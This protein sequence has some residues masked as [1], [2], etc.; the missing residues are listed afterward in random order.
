MSWDEHFPKEPEAIIRIALGIDPGRWKPWSIKK[1]ENRETR[2]QQ[3]LRY[4]RYAIRCAHRALAAIDIPTE[5]MRKAGAAELG[6]LFETDNAE[7]EAL[8]IWQAMIRSNWT[9]R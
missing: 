9:S 1:L 7:E 4:K 2:A 5:L 3:H 6:L 8:R